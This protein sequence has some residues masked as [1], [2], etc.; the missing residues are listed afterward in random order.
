MA[1]PRI[2]TKERVLRLT[3]EQ[4]ASVEAE[5]RREDKIPSFANMVRTLL[6]E[7]LTARETVR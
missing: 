7:A 1:R 3:D 5:R 2:F 4:E 6:D